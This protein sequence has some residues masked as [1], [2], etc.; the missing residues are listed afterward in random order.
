MAREELEFAGRSYRERHE[1]A[2][3]RQQLMA[4]YAEGVRCQWR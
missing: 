2:P 3:L 4:D 1:R